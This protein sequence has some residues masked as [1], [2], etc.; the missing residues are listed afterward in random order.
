M[1][2][3]RFR[4]AWEKYEYRWMVKPTSNQEWPTKSNK[5]WGGE[6]DTDLVL[7]REQGIGDDILFLGLVMEAYKRTR[8]LT[9]YTDSR[10]IS[11]CERGMPGVVFKPYKNKIDDEDFDYHL[12]MGSLPRLFRSDIKDFENT[13]TGYLKADKERVES[14]REELGLGDKKVVG[15]S[16]KSIKSLHTQKK[17]LSLKEFGTLFKDLDIVLLNLQYGDVDNEIKEFTKSTGI[18]VLQCGSVD[19]RED[20]DGLAALIELCDLVVST[21]NVTVH[22][23]GALGKETWVLLPYVANFWWLL[24]RTDSIWYPTLRLYRQKKFQDWGNVLFTV[25]TDLSNFFS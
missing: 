21:S 11:L 19:N 8:F 3:N 18:E 7:W 22:L 12:P 24:D 1:F 9:V 17:S 25:T 4:E 14:L 13:V 10:L 2:T 5:K 15:I 6:E 20:L 16:W 23:A